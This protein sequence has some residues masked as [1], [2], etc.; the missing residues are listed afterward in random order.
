LGYKSLDLIITLRCLSTPPHGE[1]VV[2]LG[3]SGPSTC[4]VRISCIQLLELFSQA[5]FCSSRIKEEIKE[6]R[7]RG[8]ED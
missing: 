7:R 1:D 5:C 3:C 2:V 4:V 6:E 8:E